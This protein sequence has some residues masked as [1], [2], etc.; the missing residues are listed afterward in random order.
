M[1]FYI[2]FFILFKLIELQI[3]NFDSMNNINIEYKTED[4]IYFKEYYQNIKD[5]FSKNQILNNEIEN[6]MQNITVFITF[7]NFVIYIKKFL[8]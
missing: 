1:K 2:Y 7:F 3:I 6:L 4:D 8:Y 5:Y